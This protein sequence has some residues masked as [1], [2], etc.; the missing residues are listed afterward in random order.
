MLKYFDKEWEYISTNNDGIKIF[1]NRDNDKE[2][3]AH[4]V[5]ILPQYN[6]NK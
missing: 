6:L 2:A 1:R 4:N 3:E 5:A